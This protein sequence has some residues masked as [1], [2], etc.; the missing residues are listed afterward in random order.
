M[1]K[2]IEDILTPKPVAR[3]RIYA[4][5]IDDKAHD[6]LLKIGQTTRD[7]KQRIAEQLKT[8][9]IKNYKIELDE[10]AERD[11]G[12]IYSDH[13]VRAALIRK[14]FENTEL[15]WVQCAIRDV[16][17]VLTELR[18]GQQSTGNAVVEH[19]AQTRFEGFLHTSLLLSTTMCDAPGYFREDLV[20]H[21]AIAMY[22]AI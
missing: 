21:L 11:D 18:T 19:K 13:E 22:S 10:S 20:R 3:P 1:S 15:E 14:K 17:T 5:S 2:P 12:T 9:A 4:Y 8:A 6:G 7:V 16:K